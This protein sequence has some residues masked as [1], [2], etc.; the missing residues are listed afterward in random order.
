M[1]KK[2]YDFDHFYG[3]QLFTDND[4]LN[5]T[6]NVDAGQSMAAEMKTFYVNEL[7]QFA[8]PNLV[9]KQFA[10]IIPLPKNRG[11]AIEVRYLSPFANAGQLTE[12]ETPTGTLMNWN[13]IT[14]TLRQYGDFVPFSDLVQMTTYDPVIIEVTKKLGAQAGKTIDA[15][16]RDE[17]SGGTNVEYA[18]NVS[19][20]TETANVARNTMDET[21]TMTVDLLFKAAAKLK[22]NDAPTI[23]GHYVAIM[24]PYIASDLMRTKEWKDIVCHRDPD[25]IYNGEIGMIADI[26][27]VEST[28]AKIVAESCIP[29]TDDGETTLTGSAYCTVVVGQDAYCF[30]ELEG[31]GMEHIVKQLGYAD[32]LNQRGSVGWKSACLAKRL[33]ENY[34]VRIET[35]SKT[36]PTADSN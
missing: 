2:F 36:N 26:V 28:N 3:L 7:L 27:V 19:G 32:E 34:I 12:G 5:V 35:T 14:E 33:I 8:E 23:D 1:I 17:V 15:Y 11:K 6:Y 25:K 31:Q 10:K 20:G 30:T 9:F 13:A 21:A 29:V 4:D 18:P 24:H 16:I 22:A